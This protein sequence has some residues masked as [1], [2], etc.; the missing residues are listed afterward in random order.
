MVTQISIQ[1]QLPNTIHT[2]TVYSFQYKCI[3]E[4]QCKHLNHRK[5]KLNRFKSVVRKWIT[6]SRFEC[7]T[8]GNNHLKSFVIIHSTERNCSI[9]KFYSFFLLLLFIRH[10]NSFDIIWY[11]AH[12]AHI[13]SEYAA[14]VMTPLL[15]NP[16]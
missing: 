1:W 15:A 6:L 2:C 8:D 9:R 14:H 5:M 7:Q 12:I 10:E 3:L 16:T 13:A 11:I 4:W